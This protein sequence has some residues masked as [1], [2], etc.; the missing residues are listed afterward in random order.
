MRK[1]DKKRFISEM[2]RGLRIDMLARVDHM[3]EDWDGHELRE[4]LAD[5]AREYYATPLKGSRKREYNNARL[6]Q[7]I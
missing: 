5:L 3:P 2:C 6:V 7:N 4:L 1:R